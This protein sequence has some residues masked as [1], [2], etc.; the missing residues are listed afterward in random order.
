MVC[1]P[2]GKKSFTTCLTISTEYWRVTDRQTDIF[3]QHSPRNA[4]ASRGKTQERQNDT[5][6]A[7]VKTTFQAQHTSPLFARWRYSS[8][9][10]DIAALKLFQ[11]NSLGVAAQQ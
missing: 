9:L 5:S 3:P 10:H 4:Y 6:P 11:R 1:L 8:W 7:V 2:D